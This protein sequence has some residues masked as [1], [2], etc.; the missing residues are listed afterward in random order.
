[1]FNR[2]ESCQSSFSPG[3]H[4][5]VTACDDRAA[6]FIGQATSGSWS[7]KA[8]ISHNGWIYSATFSADGRYVVTASGDQSVKI[9]ELR[10]NNSLHAITE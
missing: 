3:G 7:E 10:S 4:H 5:L 9:T 6:K 2:Y 1:M 8:S